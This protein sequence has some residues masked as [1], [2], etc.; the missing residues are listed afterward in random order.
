[1]REAFSTPQNIPTEAAIN[2]KENR[3]NASFCN[4]KLEKLFTVS[5]PNK[6]TKQDLHTNIIIFKENLFF[7]LHFMDES[8]NIKCQNE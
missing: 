7:K 8:P 4:T 5:H 6:L 2:P 3:R 1:V